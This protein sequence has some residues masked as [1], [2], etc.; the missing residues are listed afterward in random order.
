MVVF[1]YIIILENNKTMHKHKLITDKWVFIGLIGILLVLVSCGRFGNSENGKS[2]T[3]IV[4]VSKHVT[5]LLFALGQGDKLVAVD[6]SSTF[7]EQAK[8]L[9]TVGYHRALSAESIISMRP[10]LVIH[11]NDIGPEGVNDQ[12]IKAGVNVKIVGGANTIDSTYLLIKE[13]GNYFKVDKEADS[14]L[15]KMKSGI[16]TAKI[17]LNKHPIL[18]TPS[19]MI[20]HF[21]RASNI[22]F[23]MSGRKGVGD[24]MIQLA[25]GKTSFYD[26]KGARQISAEAVATANPDIILAT[27]FGYDQMGSMEKFIEGVP[28]VALTNAG[29]NKRIY[30]FEEHDLVYF[31]PRTGENII[32]LI[33]LIHPSRVQKN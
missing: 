5:E 13:L 15:Q 20:I 24:K 33:Q 8:Q 18:D 31:G 16:E 17:E 32:K 2:S 7:P 19:V 27:D 3:R 12:L 1:L 30:R 28:G 23:V 29:K 6:L 9:K 10:D 4:S 26:A 25:G 14:L 11:S 22:Y 21:G